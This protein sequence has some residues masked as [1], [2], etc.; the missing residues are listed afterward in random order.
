MLKKDKHQKNLKSIIHK[1]TVNQIKSSHKQ[2]KEMNKL[3][4][5]NVSHQFMVEPHPNSIVCF[6]SLNHFQSGF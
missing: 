3:K 5:K 6:Q 2:I 1:R 4:T